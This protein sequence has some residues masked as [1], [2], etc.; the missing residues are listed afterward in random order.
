MNYSH[1]VKEMCQVKIGANHEKVE[2]KK[3]RKD[4]EC[5]IRIWHS[6]LACDSFLYFYNW[7][8]YID[9]CTVFSRL[10]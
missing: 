9:G 1:E 8:E 4:V 2:H 7:N 3:P 6:A 10:S 5:H